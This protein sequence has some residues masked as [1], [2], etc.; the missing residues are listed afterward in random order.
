VAIAD[1]AGEAGQQMLAHADRGSAAPVRASDGGSQGGRHEKGTRLTVI[2]CRAPY[3][4][5]A[6]IAQGGTTGRSAYKLRAAGKGRTEVEHRLSLDLRGVMRLAGPL[7]RLGLR[8]EHVALKR[9]IE[10]R[11]GAR[12]V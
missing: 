7:L 6:E 9:F 10:A 11:A 4:F 2:E 12:S 5:V 8:H 3:S 1:F